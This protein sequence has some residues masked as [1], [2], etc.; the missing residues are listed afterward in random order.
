MKPHVQDDDEDIAP[1]IGAS[2]VHRLNQLLGTI[3]IETDLLYDDCVEALEQQGSLDTQTIRQTLES[4]GSEVRLAL[5][6]VDQ[7]SAPWLAQPIRYR[8]QTMLGAILAAIEAIENRLAEGLLDAVYLGQGLDKI[9][10]LAR[11]VLRIIGRMRG[12]A[13][14][15]LTTPT[16]EVVDLRDLIGEAIDKCAVAKNID[17]IIDFADQP[18]PV[19]NHQGLVE[20]LINV[21]MNALEAMPDGGQLTVAL[22][23]PKNSRQVE[24]RIADTGCGIPEHFKPALF[25]PFASTKEGGQGIGLWLSKQLLHRLGGDIYLEHSKVGEGSTF[26]LTIPTVVD[27]EGD[28]INE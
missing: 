4:M 26:V 2:M 10:S 17:L 11:N 1:W 21:L 16:D 9:K 18:L 23:A 3:P 7:D 12:P 25:E 8:L 24:I 20:V 13:K 15:T 6:A 14:G 19:G 5:E 22:S 28:A 27:T